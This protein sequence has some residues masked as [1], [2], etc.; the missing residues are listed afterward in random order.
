MSKAWS[1]WHSCPLIV[2]V[3]VTSQVLRP[4][5]CSCWLEVAVT[6]YRAGLA[7]GRDLDI[8]RVGR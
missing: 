2:T 6:W 7:W 1:S 8:L 5:G 3:I 4:E